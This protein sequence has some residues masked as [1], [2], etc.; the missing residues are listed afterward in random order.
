[1]FLLVT[2]CASPA[3][4]MSVEQVS[5]LSDVQLCQLRGAYMYEPKTETEIG[6]RNLNCHPAYLECSNQGLQN[7]TP[8][9]TLCA[10]QLQEKWELQRQLQQQQVIQKQRRVIQT[11]GTVITQY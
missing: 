8:E 7:G 5:Q 2:A 3:Q 10:R 11:P 1:M 4:N 9:M 6:R